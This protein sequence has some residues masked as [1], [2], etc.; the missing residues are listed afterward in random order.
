MLPVLPDLNGSGKI[1][2]MNYPESGKLTRTPEAKQ[3]FMFLLSLSRELNS[4]L[5]LSAKYELKIFLLN[6]KLFSLVQYF[7]TAIFRN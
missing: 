4:K 1:L 5:N 3:L 6:N 2:L 7:D